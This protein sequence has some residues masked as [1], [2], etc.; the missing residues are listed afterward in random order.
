LEAFVVI[1]QDCRY[2]DV[3]NINSNPEKVYER[4][5]PV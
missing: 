2:S 3:R 1:I 5:F 4:V